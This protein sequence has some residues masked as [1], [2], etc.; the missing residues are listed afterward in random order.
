[1]YNIIMN[2]KKLK[3]LFC[4][5]IGN[6]E[7]R[8]DTPAPVI[9]TMGIE[10]K[11]GLG[12]CGVTGTVVVYKM[13]TKKTVK[14]HGELSKELIDSMPEEILKNPEDKEK[15]KIT[16]EKNDAPKYCIE[17]YTKIFQSQDEKLKPFQG[18]ICKIL[19]IMN[20]TKDTDMYFEE[21]IKII[22]SIPNINKEFANNLISMLNKDKIVE[23]FYK[24]LEI[25]STNQNILEFIKTLPENLKNLD[26]KVLMGKD[27]AIDLIENLPKEIEISF[28]FF[29]NLGFISLENKKIEITENDKK[30][31]KEGVE[32][33]VN[34]IVE[35]LKN[36]QISEDNIIKCL[37]FLIYTVTTIMPNNSDLINDST[38]FLGN[39]LK[40]PSSLIK[41]ASL[42]INKN[43][44]IPIDAFLKV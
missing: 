2:I 29:S 13:A 6:T 11:V 5:N 25:M 27:A 31:D 8:M 30:S 22:S 43:Q 19:K 1:M 20:E 10:A 21:F 14:S 9:K 23:N 39:L 42:M 7:A 32:N 24:T 36:N 34:K 35:I 26:N 40:D 41:R 18:F 28:E 17:S 3:L 37:F 15:I 38:K 44:P 16:L 12:V 33:T 4:L